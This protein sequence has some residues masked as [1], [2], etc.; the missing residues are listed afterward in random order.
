MSNSFRVVNESHGHETGDAA[1]RQVAAALRSV[2]RA[3]D[4][5]ARTGA[6]EFLILCPDTSLEAAQVCADRLRIAVENADIVAGML[7]LRL[8]ASI[9]VAC[10]DS[11]VTDADT[12]VRR[13][14][15][16]MEIAKQ[17]GRN[18]VSAVQ[19]RPQSA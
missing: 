2:L 4:V 7:A 12:L 13:A 1:L 18:R 16:G 19:L 3:H 17:S 10:R 8:T 14:E 6:D 11:S 9:G 5:V 15:Q